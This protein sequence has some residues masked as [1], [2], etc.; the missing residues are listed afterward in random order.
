MSLI[1]IKKISQK[2]K[3]LIILHTWINDQSVVTQLSFFKVFDFS[4]KIKTC[5]LNSP[6][7]KTQFLQ[8]KY[9]PDP[10]LNPH[11]KSQK[12][13]LL[14]PIQDFSPKFLHT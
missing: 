11:K 5:V 13:G 6:M 2:L 8:Y 9:K 14:L 3:K 1:L 7:E 12:I 10:G 4:E